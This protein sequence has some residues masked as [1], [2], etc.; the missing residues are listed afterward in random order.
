MRKPL[1]I[2]PFLFAIFPILFLFSHNI[3]Q[4]YFSETLLPSSITL[5]VTILLVLS[6]GLIFRDK[7]K[8]GIIV[9][10]F[11]ILFFSY[12][13]VHDLINVPLGKGRYLLA[14]WGLLI[15]GGSY[16]V[17]RTRRRLGGV[18]YVLNMVAVILCLI[19]VINIV[20]YK[21]KDRH[22]SEYIQGT[23]NLE[24][25]T[26]NLLKS[27]ELPDIYYIVLDR[28]LNESVLEEGYGFNNREF[29]DYL[30]QKGFYVVHKSRCNYVGTD[31]S[32]ASS[33]NMEHVNTLVREVGEGSTDRTIIY[34]MLQDYKVWRFLRAIGY[35][36]IHFGS[37]WHPTSNNR[38]ADMNYSYCSIP[39]FSM[40]LW[41][42]TLFFPVSVRLGI[43]DPRLEQWKRVRYK[44]AK[45][46]EI[47][48]MEEPTFV[49]AHMLIPHDP[50]VFNENGMFMSQQDVDRRREKDNYIG[51]LIFANRE[52]SVLIN[53]L[54]SHA[55]VAPIIILQSDEGPE[56]TEEEAA[57]SLGKSA[58]RK[59]FGILNA[60]YLPEGGSSVLY[61]DITPVNT[62][63]LV[64]NF[65]FN[66]HLE[67]LP[68]ESFVS[69]DNGKPFNFVNV[70]GK[71]ND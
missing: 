56:L 19:S 3:E 51:Q 59:R 30:Y 1:V 7:K 67:L 53:K 68:D 26:L 25:N 31:L 40:V 33:L 15:G 20:A 23:P 65:Y 8:A 42:T 50:F 4:V 71:I 9:S 48:D 38:Y 45:I 13:H 24:T 32:L 58:L 63:R 57:D 18:T 52:L 28:Y 11:L 64:F 41:K 61:P 70:T 55:K 21:F 5:G 62:F 37:W 60:Y 22:T 14:T 69:E 27:S 12:G 44:F 34:E 43:Y 36:F 46:A 2:H 10:I 16:F 6:L 47:A 39:E 66:A 54:L 35:K 29:I 49:F 17:I